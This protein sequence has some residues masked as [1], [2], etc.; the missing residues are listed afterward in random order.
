MPNQKETGREPTEQERELVFAPNQSPKK[1]GDGDPGIKLPGTDPDG[2]E[3]AD[4]N[5][6]RTKPEEQAD[7]AA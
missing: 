4:D 5:V 1:Q 2:G 3:P 7:G 6:T